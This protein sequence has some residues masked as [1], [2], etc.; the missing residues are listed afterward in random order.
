MTQL[1][2]ISITG[3]ES[4]GKSWLAENLARHYST[5]WV[6]EYSREYLSSLGRPYRPEDIV[7]IAKGQLRIENEAALKSDSMLFCDTDL[8]VNMI[9]S[10]FKYGHC[11]PW[12]LDQA[13]I[14]RYDLYL[15]CNID[16]P[17]EADPLREHPDKRKILFDLYQNNLEKMDVKWVVISGTGNERLMNAIKAVESAL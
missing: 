4:T 14:H 13:M 8:L 10:E 1:K 17:W 9:W 6:P 7:N 16:L 3:P 15:L 2:R 11:D 5:S 12:I